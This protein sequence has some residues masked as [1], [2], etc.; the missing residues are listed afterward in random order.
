[1]LT[2]ILALAAMQT[3]VASSAP[4]PSPAAQTRRPAAPATGAIDIRVTDRTGRT[5]PGARISAE[6]PTSREAKSDNSGFVGFRTMTA[7]TYRLRG[8]AEGYFTFEKE[9]SVKAGPALPVELALSPAPPPPEPPPPPP[10][11]AAPPA[12]PPSLPAG[13]P[14]VL[15][16]LDMAERSLS[17]RE[18]VR[19]VPIGCSGQSTAQLKVV[20]ETLQ[21]PAPAD[22]DD[23][24]YVIAGEG[25]VMQGGKSTPVTA[26]WFSIVPR[27]STATVARKGRNPIIL[28][29]IVGGPVCA[30]AAGGQ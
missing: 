4:A 24:L 20:R 1:M 3:P 2:L 12:A 10:V 30:A 22:A 8:E 11:V 6:G 19:T 29:S 5:I 14:R 28:L 15:S 13:D 27:G 17:G 18:P 9:V 25:T 21:S 26:G 7:G 23:M 16:L